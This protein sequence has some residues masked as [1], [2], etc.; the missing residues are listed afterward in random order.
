MYGSSEYTKLILLIN[1][2]YSQSYDVLNK[3][4][5]R[6]DTAKNQIDKD[7]LETKTTKYNVTAVYG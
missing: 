4:I 1:K 3:S 7:Y 6:L 2:Q 5:A